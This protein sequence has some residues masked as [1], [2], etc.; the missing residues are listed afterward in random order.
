[1]NRKKLEEVAKIFQTLGYAARTGG[2]TSFVEEL[3]RWHK[4]LGLSYEW[5]AR[6]VGL[7]V[8]EV[9][10]LIEEWEKRKESFS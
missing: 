9:R 8:N 7:S 10:R 3:A 2:I 1:V 4:E 6:E 5:I